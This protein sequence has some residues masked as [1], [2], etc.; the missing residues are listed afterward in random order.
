MAPFDLLALLLPPD[1]APFPLIDHDTLQ[2]LDALMGL[3]ALYGRLGTLLNTPAPEPEDSQDEHQ[4]RIL[5][6]LCD[7]RG[8]TE[9][10]S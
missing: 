5:Q 6:A 7:H 1:R 3:T 8:N 2:S 4:A 10:S 9:V